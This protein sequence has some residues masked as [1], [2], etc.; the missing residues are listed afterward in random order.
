MEISSSFE[1]PADRARVWA[2]LTDLTRI[3]PCMPGAQVDA[4]LPDEP[5]AYSGHFSM[6]VGPVRARY[7]GILRIEEADAERGRIVLRGSGT[8]GG[9]AGSVS[10][11]ITGTVSEQNGSCRVD[12]LSEI[13]VKGRLAQFTGRS[14]MVQGIA[15][16]IIGQFAGNLV[17]ELGSAEP[18]AAP[19]AF[20]SAGASE[21]VR[22]RPA[23]ASNDLDPVG[24]AFAV[25][26]GS[27][28]ARSLGLVAASIAVGVALGRWSRRSATPRLIVVVL[29][30]RLGSP[31]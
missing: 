7:A 3:A 4:E 11:T 20:P 14:S 25:L 16:Q 15:D 24:L 22:A 18:A 1:I 6:K 19:G 17:A 26:K 13:D 21:S 27:M 2:A 28:G 12:M 31:E 23:A 5:G 29:D 30:R 10:A 8:D 9:G